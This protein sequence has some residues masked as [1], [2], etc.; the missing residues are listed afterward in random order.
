MGHILKKYRMKKEMMD[1]IDRKLNDLIENKTIPDID[2]VISSSEFGGEKVQA[3]FA[4]EYWRQALSYFNEEEILFILSLPQPGN[5]NRYLYKAAQ[6]RKIELFNE[7]AEQ[8]L[9]NE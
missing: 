3:R 2:D 9:L 7:I 8:V 4:V 1:K 5:W 6:E